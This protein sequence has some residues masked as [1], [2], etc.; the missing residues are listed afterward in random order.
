MLRR[1]NYRGRPVA[2]PL[3]ALLLAAAVVALALDQSRW[4][5]FLCG[6]GG[7][8]VLDDL[9]ADGARGWRGHG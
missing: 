7:L 1:T 5:V 8:G 2:F 9:V 3:G 4:L 6:V